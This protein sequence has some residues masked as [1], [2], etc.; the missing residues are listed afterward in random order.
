MESEDFVAMC[1][2]VFGRLVIFMKS[3]E[4]YM[5]SRTYSSFVAG[6]SFEK[7]PEKR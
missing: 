3:K 4:Y 6:S 5:L 2:K 7:Y 1:G